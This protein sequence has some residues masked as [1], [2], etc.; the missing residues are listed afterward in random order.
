LRPASRN[1]SIGG[2]SAED[3]LNRPA[4]V[5]VTSD[6]AHDIAI[7]RSGILREIPGRER[8][9]FVRPITDQRG[10]LW[11][12]VVYLSAIEAQ[13]SVVVEQQAVEA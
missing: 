11:N 2:I 7:T 13:A 8:S 6:D 12:A 9:R 10:L 3:I 1:P 5:V 4:I